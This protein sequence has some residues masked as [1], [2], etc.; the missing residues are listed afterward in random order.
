MGMRTQ[1]TKEFEK[2]SYFRYF[3]TDFYKKWFEVDT[4]YVKS[5]IFL[6]VFPFLRKDWSRQKTGHRGGQLSYREPTADVMCPDAYI[7]VM[8]MVTYLLVYGYAVALKSQSLVGSEDKPSQATSAFSPEV[9]V[10]AGSTATLILFLETIC[11]IMGF[12]FTGVSRS[13]PSFVDGMCYSGYKYLA[14]NTAVGLYTVTSNTYVY[15]GTVGIMGSTCG[16][17]LWK[18]LKSYFH[19]DQQYVQGAGGLAVQNIFLLLVGAWQIVLIF[20]LSFV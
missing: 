6:I 14:V 17:F 19:E 18:S 16:F 1:F 11:L 5:K 10:G 4:N 3:S 2:S 20:Y 9:L 8:S 13:P 7:P 12:K 15:Y